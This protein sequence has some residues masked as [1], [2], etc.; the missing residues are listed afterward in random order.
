[1]KIRAKIDLDEF[2]AV[3]D[4]CD[5][6]VELVTDEGDRYNLSSRISQCV[7]VSKFFSRGKDVPGLRI[8]ASNS[9]DAKK[10]MAFLGNV[11]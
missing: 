11:R 2:F 8:V 6:K 7:A 4:K 9:E 10:I 3:V 1:M 5:G